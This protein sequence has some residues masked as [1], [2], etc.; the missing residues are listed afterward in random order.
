MSLCDSISYEEPSDT[1]K[2]IHPLKAK[3]E[4]LVNVKLVYFFSFLFRFFWCPFRLFP[5]LFRYRLEAFPILYLSRF[6]PGQEDSEY[7]EILGFDGHL[8]DT[9][10]LS[11][12]CLQRG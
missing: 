5:H 3:L 1:D 4:F 12:L 9:E 8:S 7:V 11:F 2:Y 10:N 6:K